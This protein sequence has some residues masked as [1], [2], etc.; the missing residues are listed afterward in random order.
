MS[1]ETL[2]QYNRKRLA[3]TKIEYNPV[4]IEFHDD[5]GDLV[6]NMWYNY[7]KYYYKDPSNNDDNIAN[8][9]AGKVLA[10]WLGAAMKPGV[11]DNEWKPR[12]AGGKYDGVALSMTAKPF[13]PGTSFTQNVNSVCKASKNPDMAMKVLE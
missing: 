1:V 5:G 9:K 10:Q 6:R 2:N 7:F 3:Q 13:I 12:I 8:L 4:Q 11:V